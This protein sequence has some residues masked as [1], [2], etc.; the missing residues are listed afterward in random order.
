MEPKV[1]NLSERAR[2]ATRATWLGFIINFILSSLKLLAGIVGHSGAMVADAIHSFSD[3]ATDIILL[4]GFKV[5][6]KPADKTHDYGHGKVETLCTSIIGV[7]LFVV[8]LRILY[9]GVRNIVSS[10]GGNVIYMPG[11][12]ALCAALLSVIIKEWLYQYTI[13]V[14]KRIESQA[15]VANA[16]HHRSDALSSIGALLGIGGAIVLGGSWRILDPAAAVIVSFFIIKVSVVIFMG[17]LNELME[18]SLSEDMKD[19]ILAIAQNVPGV[20]NPHNLQTRRIGSAVAIDIHIEVNKT[21]N[22]EEAHDIATEVESQIVDIF[23]VQTFVSVHI[24]P[25]E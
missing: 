5:A 19:K 21:L 15:V 16:W 2:I 8:G 18:G 11:W 12:I 14:G 22:V 3:S 7:V 4:F 17:S 20:N 23:G 9:G 24:E 13:K 6:K 1:D 10:L 25:S